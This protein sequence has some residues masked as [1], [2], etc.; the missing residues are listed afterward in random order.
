LPLAEHGDGFNMEK[1]L[2]NN[3]RV[4][5]GDLS[6]YDKNPRTLSEKQYSDLKKSLEN[7]ESCSKET[8]FEKLK[9]SIKELI[10][11]YY[12][13]PENGAGGYLHIFLDDGNTDYSS[14]YFCQNECKEHGDT[15]GYFLCDVL[16]MFTEEELWHMYKHDRWGMRS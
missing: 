14:L 2:W 3:A 6:A 11:Y 13:M 7:C 12:Q 9:N 16:L 15:L 8:K 1:L 4:K 5:L 10:S